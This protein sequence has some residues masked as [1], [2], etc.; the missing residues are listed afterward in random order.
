[1]E[2]L[3]SSSQD[4]ATTEEQ[5]WSQLANLPE[6]LTKLRNDASHL[7]RAH[8]AGETIKLADVRQ[9]LSKAVR[10]I[11]STMPPTDDEMSGPQEYS[12]YDLLSSYWDQVKNRKKTA[13]TGFSKL[14][15]ILSGGLEPLR[16]VGVLGA[17]NTGKTTF[18]HQ[19]AD[20]IADGGRP[21]LYV[22]SEDTPSA[23][24]AK[25]LARI[26]GIKYTAVLKGWDTE[27]AAIDAALAKQVDRRSSERLR[28]LDATNGITVNEIR[29]RARALFEQF[30]DEQQGGGPGVVVVDYLQRIARS[31]YRDSG[32]MELREAVTRATNELRVLSYELNCTVVA[33]VSQN[34]Q[35][36][37][38]G[39]QGAMASAKESGDIEY[40]C[41]VMMALNEDKDKGRIVPDGQTAIKLFVDKN[42]QGQRGKMV[43]LN[44]WP[45]RQEFTQAAD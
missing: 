9:V 28:Y 14:D 37:Q 34:R 21:V 32:T 24:F 2:K 43:D 1:M 40:T 20:H 8:E 25:T 26:G 16:L 5:A 45:D 44:F 29:K 13:G 4:N 36:Y 12:V 42:R 33:I 15:D 3:T 30:S 6:V 38:R 31:L 7:N 10:S 18:T 27:R 17:P 23:L 41:D 35:S 22:T 39:E 19:L 11:E